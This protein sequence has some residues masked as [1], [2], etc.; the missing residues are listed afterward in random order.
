VAE[1]LGE[2]LEGRTEVNG[3]E[4]LVYGIGRADWERSASAGGAS[5]ER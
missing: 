2:R 4:A 5:A 3:H 1:R